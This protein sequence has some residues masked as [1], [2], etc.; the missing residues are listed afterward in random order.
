MCCN[1]YW[2]KQVDLKTWVYL[3]YFVIGFT[4]FSI[5]LHST[6]DR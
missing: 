4:D 3:Q 5:L 2:K 6:L 1:K